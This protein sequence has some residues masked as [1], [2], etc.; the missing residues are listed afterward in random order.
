MAF[1][2]LLDFSGKNVVITGGLGRIGFEASRAFLEHGA[3]VIVADVAEGRLQELQR[4]PGGERCTFVAFDIGRLEGIGET[5]AHVV[6]TYHHVD[7]WVNM[8]YPRSA[9]WGARLDDVQ[10]ASW[11]ENIRAHLGGYFW[12]SKHILEHMKKQNGGSLINFGS[13][14]GVV[15]PNFSVYEDTTMTVPVAYAAIKG[16]LVNLTRYFAAFYGPFNVR[17]N[18]IAPGGVVGDQDPRFVERYNALTPLKRM[19]KAE[20]LAMPTL[21]LASPAASYVTGHTLMVDGGWTSW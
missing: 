16:A 6:A 14:Y 9:D 2:E 21:F 17:V 13:I 8:A 18:T 12:S 3:N 19:A 11:D 15:G 4:A 10:V 1:K 5:I 20:E 7:A